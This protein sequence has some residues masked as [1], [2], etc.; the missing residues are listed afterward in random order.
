MVGRVAM[1]FGLMA[2]AFALF[3]ISTD[4]LQALGQ[5][6]TGLGEVSKHAGEGMVDA[7]PKVK[8]LMY[9]LLGMAMIIRMSGLTSSIRAMGTGFMMMGIGAQMAVAPLTAMQTPLTLIATA[10]G[11]WA[12]NM[13]KLMAHFPEFVGLMGGLAM[14]LLGIGWAWFGMLALSGM[15]WS[16]A[17]AINSVPNE[18]VVQFKEVFDTLE[19]VTPELQKITPNVVDNVTDLVDQAHS[20]KRATS[21]WLFGFDD[22]FAEM[23]GM[24]Q[25]ASSRRAGTAAQSEPKTIILELDKHELGRTVTK[26]VNEKY[27]ARL[28]D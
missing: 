26:L 21:G 7:V 13:G 28:K 3:W 2:L 12:T 9:T 27:K 24:A 22:R 11:L 25:G 18:K 14:A 15:F 20:Y 23:L 16:L 17:G 19:E 10:V 5:M 8:S 1:S 6:M 4:D